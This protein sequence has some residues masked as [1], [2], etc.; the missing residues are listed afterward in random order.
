VLLFPL[1]DLA[2]L[3]D[4]MTRQRC[5]NGCRWLS[6]EQTLGINAR[7]KVGC[8]EKRKAAKSGREMVVDE[9]LWNWT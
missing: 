1:R 9:W 8:R 6:K 7:T 2:E 4:R 3:Q 5:W